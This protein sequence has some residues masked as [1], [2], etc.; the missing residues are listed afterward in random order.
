MQ[1]WLLL[2]GLVVAPG[3]CSVT[4]VDAPVSVHAIFVAPA[5]LDQLSG[6]AFLDHPFPSDVRREP[7]GKVRFQGFY[8][9]TENVL[10]DSF[11]KAA[12]G[13]LD[14]F[15]PSASGYLRFDGYLDPAT[16]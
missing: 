11:V 16:R 5:S 2:F 10:I 9:P 7:D 12:T 8:N 4:L 6:E 1:K 14:G 13:L 15:S 3:A